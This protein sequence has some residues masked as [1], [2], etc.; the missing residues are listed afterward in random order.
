MIIIII[1]TIIILDVSFCKQLSNLAACLLTNN[2]L[3]ISPS[4]VTHFLA[5]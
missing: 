5:N 1:I 4:A 3:L 2:L